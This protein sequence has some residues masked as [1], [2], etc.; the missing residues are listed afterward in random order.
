MLVDQHGYYKDEKK[1]VQTSADMVE[2]FHHLFAADR[3]R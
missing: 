3:D 2:E 1:M